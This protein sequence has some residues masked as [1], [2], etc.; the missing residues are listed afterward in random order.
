MTIGPGSEE[1]LQKVLERYNREGFT[2]QFGSR[3][4]GQLR[5]FTCNEDL[6]PAKVALHALH[7]LEGASDPS[8]EVAVAALECPRCSARGTVALGYGPL[9]SKE[10]AIVLKALHDSRSK[11]T[12]RPGV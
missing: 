9:A 5:C 2:G 1:T 7:R 11:A 8:D 4:G 6:D 10:D 3:P 12:L